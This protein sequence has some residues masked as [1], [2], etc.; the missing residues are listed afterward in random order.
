MSAGDAW[1]VGDNDSRIGLIGTAGFSSTWRTRDNIEQT[2]GS[3]DLSVIDKDYRRVGT[4]NRAVT[5]AML[6]LNYEFGAGSKL[7]WTNF[8]VHDTL[9]HTSLASGFQNNQRLGADYLEQTTA[10]Y[11][12]QLLSTQLTA[13][14]RLDPVTI[15]APRV[16]FEI[17]ARCAVRTRHRLPAQQPGREPL[18]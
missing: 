18:W 11:E 6:G 13:D 15:G 5:N 12:R 1:S 16:V 8:Y 7:R 10:W 4:D 17:Q 2:P 14:I 3:A 9:K